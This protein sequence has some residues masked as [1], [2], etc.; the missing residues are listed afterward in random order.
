MGRGKATSPATRYKVIAD[1]LGVGHFLHF[2]D[3]GENGSYFV[4][5]DE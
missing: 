2:L 1:I 3:F 5:F 4:S